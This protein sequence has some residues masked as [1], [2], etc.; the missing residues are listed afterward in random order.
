MENQNKPATGAPTNTPPVPP[1]PPKKKKEESKSGGG[2]KGIIIALVIVV[3]ALGGLTGYL[4]NNKSELEATLA[5]QQTTIE[6]KTSEIDNMTVELEDQIARYEKLAADYA[7]IG[8]ENTELLEKAEALRA[9]VK[10]WKNS[11]GSNASQRRALE[12]ELDK[13]KANAQVDLIAK[14][15]ELQRIKLFA[16]S[17]KA[18]NDSLHVAQGQMVEENTSLSDLVRVAS[19]LKAEGLTVTAINDKNKEYDGSEFKTKHIDKLRVKFQ[20]A[21]NKVAKKDTKELILRIIE[22]SGTVLFDLSS[23]GGSFTN[24]EGKTDFYTDKQNVV[25]DNSKQTITFLYSK[26]SEYEE[27]TYKV[28]IYGEGYLIGEGSFVVK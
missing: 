11:A 5:T 15:E 3:L 19:V 13:M 27:G 7:A 16:D 24:A 25:F 1:V 17:L 4:F 22:P 26:G 28:E 8:E 20:L 12:K 14:D 2:N 21:E 23:G 6:T 18:S 9:E 10:K